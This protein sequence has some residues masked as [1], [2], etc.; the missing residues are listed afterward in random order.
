MTPQSLEELLDIKLSNCSNSET[1]DNSDSE[2]SLCQ[3]KRDL[4]E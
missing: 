2:E 1:L 4:K 3:R